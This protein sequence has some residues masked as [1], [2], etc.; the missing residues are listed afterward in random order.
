MPELV[1]CPPVEV[2][3]YLL[4]T[5][6]LESLKATIRDWIEKEKEGGVPPQRMEKRK[7]QAL[8]K[9]YWSPVSPD[10]DAYIEKSQSYSAVWNREA[11]DMAYHFHG[12]FL[13]IFLIH[14]A[15]FHN[16]Q[17]DQ[18]PKNIDYGP[19]K[20]SERAPKKAKDLLLEEV[21]VMKRTKAMPTVDVPNPRFRDAQSAPPIGDVLHVVREVHPGHS[22]ASAG[23]GIPR[24]QQQSAMNT[25]TGG[26]APHNPENF[27]PNL[28]AG[29]PT[30]GITFSVHP[31]IRHTDTQPSI[32]A[33]HSIPTYTQF[34]DDASQY[35]ETGR[36]L[37]Y[38]A[39]VRDA[40]TGSP[41]NYIPHV[42]NQSYAHYISPVAGPSNPQVHA[43]HHQLSA[44]SSYAAG[45]SISTFCPASYTQLHGDSSQYFE[46]GQPLPDHAQVRDAFTGLPT[47]YGP[48]VANQ[49][50]THYISPFAGPSNPQVH[51]THYQIP[52]TS[53]Y[54]N[55]QQA[56]GGAD[57]AFG[58]YHANYGAG[59]SG[60]HYANQYLDRSIYAQNI[61]PLSPYQGMSFADGTH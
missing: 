4:A 31:S 8:A 46:T 12:V 53:S 29:R 27:T 1:D 39:Q 59:L 32:A 13:E 26:F 56:R 57:S 10:S 55:N 22:T 51:A 44:T 23:N 6:G 11:I 49:S 2:S 33:G 37:P 28:T 20:N 42:V 60:N 25:F 5:I 15:I 9:E 47:H 36:Q 58:N 48:H 21:R 43:T 38:H 45:H 30:P 52:A 14:A 24:N 54:S 17:F 35:F 40:G 18:W 50:N 16:F 3:N 7:L 34:N 41:T 61:A 19:L